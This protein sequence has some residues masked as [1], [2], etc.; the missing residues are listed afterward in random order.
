MN[1]RELHVVQRRT[2]GESSEVPGKDRKVDTLLIPRAMLV[3]S[4]LQGSLRI[5]CSFAYDQT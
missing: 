2:P 3:A 4:A 5:G 1:A